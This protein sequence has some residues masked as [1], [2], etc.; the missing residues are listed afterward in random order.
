MYKEKM[1]FR[2]IDVFNLKMKMLSKRFD[3]EKKSLDLAVK[4]RLS[5]ES[6]IFHFILMCI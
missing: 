4:F 6:K 2:I 1:L 5:N 3:S